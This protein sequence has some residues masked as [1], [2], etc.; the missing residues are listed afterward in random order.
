MF[1]FALPLTE[2]WIDVGLGF[3]G[4]AA[5]P[6]VTFCAS[7][8]AFLEDSSLNVGAWLLLDRVI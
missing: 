6:G 7:N 1:K 8:R 4:Y 5:G 2:K 3:I